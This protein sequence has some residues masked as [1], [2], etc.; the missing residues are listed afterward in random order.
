MWLRGYLLKR[1]GATWW[2]LMLKNLQ[3]AMCYHQQHKDWCYVCVTPRPWAS[4]ATYSSVLHDRPLS[5]F[6]TYFIFPWNIVPLTLSRWLK[7]Q[8]QMNRYISHWF[9]KWLFWYIINLYGKLHLLVWKF[10]QKGH[11]KG[12]KKGLKNVD[13]ANWENIPI[14]SKW[15]DRLCVPQYSK[16]YRFIWRRMCVIT[17]S[18]LKSV[19]FWRI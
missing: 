19:R 13:C 8:F 12:P 3:F 14:F 9:L 2:K 1:H 15:I 4:H 18:F 11:W 17:H 10:L 7:Q 5:P 6:S 16:I